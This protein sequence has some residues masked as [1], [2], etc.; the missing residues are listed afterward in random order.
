VSSTKSLSRAKLNNLKQRNAFSLQSSQPGFTLAEL[1]T[2]VGILFIVAA[3]GLPKIITAAHMSR[4]RGGA[5]AIASVVQQARAYAERRNTTVNVYRGT[6]ATGSTGAF[7]DTTGYGSS[8]H[9][10][11]IYATYP[12]N[13][14]SGS[15]SNAPGNLSSSAGFTVSTAS[16]LSFNS[17]GMASAGLIYY[18]TDP[19]GDWAAVAISPLGR[20][21]VWVWNGAAWQ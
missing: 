7:A 2:V 13:V 3:I 11:D 17:L 12:A 4:V 16:S 21:K 10:G 18:V 5:D 9:I 1:V 14:T 8:F 15:S 20:A 19:Y 6:V